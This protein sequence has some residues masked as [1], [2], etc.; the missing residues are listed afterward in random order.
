[1]DYD[2][3]VLTMTIMPSFRRAALLRC[4]TEKDNVIINP[5]L[6]KQGVFRKNVCPARPG[7]RTQ[8]TKR[9]RHF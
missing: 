3:V 6:N 5:K 9:N 4:T 7:N 8:D 2:M 1:M